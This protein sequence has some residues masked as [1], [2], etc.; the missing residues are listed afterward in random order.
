MVETIYQ[1][2][3]YEEAIDDR[4]PIDPPLAADEATW[5]KK[6]LRNRKENV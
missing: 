2:Y 4:K 3:R 1:R 5:L 6:Q